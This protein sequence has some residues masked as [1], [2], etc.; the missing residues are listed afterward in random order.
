MNIFDS[1]GSAAKGAID[2]VWK[3]VKNTADEVGKAADQVGKQAAKVRD[4]ATDAVKSI[5]SQVEMPSL[6]EEQMSDVLDKCYDAALHGIPK[7]SKSS[8]ALAQEYLD[9]YGSPEKAAKAFIANQIAKCSVSG[10]VT[11]FGGFL[12]MPVTIPANISSVIYVQMRMIA[13][14][15]YMGGYDTREDEVQTLAYLCLVGT[16]ITDIVKKTGVEV[17]NKVT[18]AMLKKLPG[19]VLIAINKKVGFRLLTKFGSKGAVN[20][21]KVVPVAGAL[22]GAGMDF[23]GTKVI[24]DKA[25]NAFLLNNID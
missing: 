8:D 20:L 19:A 18:M 13:A 3:T 21:V 12:T 10:F 22:V 5:S 23:A 2:G 11:G 15:A 9:R 14:L 6:T 24:A 17:A 1:V 7:V 25:Y 16:S 4:D